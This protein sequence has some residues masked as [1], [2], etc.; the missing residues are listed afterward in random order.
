MKY[1]APRLWLA[2]LLLL[3][4]QP[5]G[6]AGPRA[7]VE[8]LDRPV[9]TP[10]G[11]SRARVGAI[12]RI[13]GTIKL[14]AEPD[15]LLLSDQGGSILS[16]RGGSILSDQGGSIISN[17]TGRVVSNNGA[18]MLGKTKFYGLRDASGLAVY[19]LADA[20]VELLDAAGRAVL[21]ESGRPLEAIS[22]P[23]GS[24]RIEAVLPPGN[25]VARITLWNGGEL[26]AIVTQNG[27]QQAT[28]DITTA[29]SLGAAYVLGLA[30]GD[31]A[32]LNK[33]PGSENDKL[34]QQLDVVRAFVIGAF[35]H[36][37]ATLNAIT[38]KLRQ[39]VPAVDKV[40]DDVKALLLGQASLGAGRP[41]T[42]VPLIGAHALYGGPTG[43]LISERHAGRIRR[44]AGDGTLQ[45]VLDRTFGTI[46]ANHPGLLDLVEAPDATLYFTQE[47]TFQVFRAAPG[48]LPAPVLGSGNP[49]QGPIAAPLVM[50]VMPRA[51]ALGLDGTLWVGEGYGSGR[52]AKDLKPPRVLAVR[53]DGTIEAYEDPAWQT[54]EVVRLA[55]APDGTVWVLQARTNQGRICR[56]REGRFEP[57]GEAF[58]A[59]EAPALALAPDGRLFMSQAN[60]AGIVVLGV[61][62]S[63]TPLSEVEALR[64]LG[65]EHPRAMTFDNAGTLY[66]ASA[67]GTLV[68]ALP[69]GAPPRLVAGTQA[70]FQTGDGQA[71][72]INGPGGLAVDQ[73]QRLYIS[74]IGRSAVRVFDGTKL[75]PFA[76]SV[77]G[78][79]GDGGPATQ[80]RLFDPRGIMWQG[81]RLWILDAGNGVL[82]RVDPDGTIHT[83]APKAEENAPQAVPP[84]G[85]YERLLMYGAMTLTAGTRGEPI[86]SETR[87]RQIQRLD[88]G[89]PLPLFRSV[90]GAVQ[91]LTAGSNWAGLLFTPPALDPLAIRLIFPFGLATAPDGA[92]YVSDAV[93]NQIYR[94]RGYD[95]ASPVLEHVAGRHVSTLLSG[96]PKESVAGQEEG[97]D[98]RTVNLAHPLGLACDAAGNLY[99]SEAGTANLASWLP[100]L[101]GDL[102]FDT[103]VL[104]QFPARVRRIS[105]A[106]TIT[107]VA[108]PGGRFLATAGDEAGLVMPTGVACFGDGRLAI[109]DSGS[110]LIHILPA[111]GD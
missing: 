53:P 35:R 66:L 74:E 13:L 68:G 89:G 12:T 55:A 109:A 95:T 7:P 86:W 43:L 41:A 101:D 75:E 1:L 99:V 108:G 42:E 80:A 63:K 52:P 102:P 10:T 76:G 88:L 36:D 97:A 18:S 16:D 29:S 46:K 30:Q 69:P 32:I 84:G 82:R 100:A 3:G 61:D 17:S 26:R 34:N 40:A 15:A 8:K 27:A 45:A 73:Q 93:A 19:G 28:V 107:T 58:Q 83:A 72:A 2:A 50:G 9:L 92:L 37:D 110:N 94:V 67:D 11:A 22:G 59:L 21:D 54:G 60:D 49:V 47:N 4:C 33:L 103:S 48:Q 5:N 31:Q 87:A 81:D 24:Y 96:D 39:R 104:P 77:K 23:D 111:A 98:A 62:G 70:V 90:M 65:L 44:L 78:Y 105:P 56:L 64:A 79:A 14:I 71:F 20:R 91:D 57:V 85:S 6:P 51:L 25:L 38:A 106:G